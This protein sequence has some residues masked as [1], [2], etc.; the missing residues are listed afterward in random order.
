[1]RLVR[2]W[3]AGASGNV[4]V[5]F[6]LTVI[7]LC[8]V[9][10]VAIDYLRA[11]NLRLDL[12]GVVDA[13]V[14]AAGAEGGDDESVLRN[15]ISLY[16][17]ANLRTADRAALGAV[18]IS[19]G[20]PATIRVEAEATSQNA[21]LK[22]VGIDR[23]PVA[24]TSEAVR[25]NLLEVALVL[26]SS[27]S[28]GLGGKDAALRE[29]VA[30]LADTLMIDEADVKL[31]VVPFSS[32]VNV[33]VQ[34]RSAPWLELFVL[35]PDQ[36]WDGCARSRPPPLDVSDRSP[37]VRYPMLPTQVSERP[38][39]D[40]PGP[41][42]P[43]TVDKSVITAAMSDM[44]FQSRTYIP[45]GLM[46]GWNVLSPAPPFTE[47][48]D[49]G[50]RKAMVLMTDGK[51]SSAITEAGFHLLTGNPDPANKATLTLCG[52]IRQAGI[53]LYTVAFQIPDQKTIDVLRHC[54]SDRDSAFS[55][56][57]GHA[58]VQ[59]FGDITRHLQKLRLAR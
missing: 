2:S 6:A 16:I 14:L 37:E 8:T 43:L 33:G 11:S 15:T 18:R 19:F 5:A 7:P 29:A 1:M 57:N 39:A 55:A 34:N 41:L 30:E 13:A 47:A 56:D 53:H 48:R 27:A 52:N 20:K 25:A 31:A 17:D 49:R 45:D 26:D 59:A 24:V 36:R 32:Y 28:M 54:A 23:T 40:C 51:N 9:L 21:L 50:V 22:L 44:V 3:W 12:Q 35:P 10:G 58:L 38:N 42:T 4:G 46:W